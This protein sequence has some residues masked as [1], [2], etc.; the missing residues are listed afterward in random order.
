MRKTGVA[1]DFVILSAVKVITAAS[2]ML[3]TAILSR[4]YSLEQY[5]TYSQAL[6]TMTM[7]SALILFALADASNYFFNR[8]NDEVER[9]RYTNT[10]FLIETAVGF[11]AALLIVG[12]RKSI[13]DYYDNMALLPLT[14]VMALSPLITNYIVLYQVLHVSI[15]NART[16]SVRNLIWAALK[17]GL[18]LTLTT[19]NNS[20]FWM[21]LALLIVDMLSVIYYWVVFAQKRFLVLPYRINIS[22]V[23]HVLR[24]AIPMAAYTICKSLSREISKLFVSRLVGVE[25]LAIF[26]NAAKPLPF[27]LILTAM[28][29]IVMPFITRY[30]NMKDKTNIKKLLRLYFEIGYMTMWIMAGCTLLIPQEIISFLYGDKYLPGRDVFVVYVVY[31]ILQFANISL[32]LSARGKT[33]TLI[34][35]ASI[36]LAS[37]VGLTYVL[38]LWGGILGAAL[39]TLLSSVVTLAL[40]QIFSLQEIGARLCDVFEKTTLLTFMSRAALAAAITA[41]LAWVTAR[42]VEAGVIRLLVVY[43]TFV[44]TTAAFNHKLLISRMKE[45][46]QL[47]YLI[48]DGEF[49]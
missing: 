1:V 18:A 6:I 40:L 49:E 41:A 21:L 34:R 29:T 14:Y 48:N 17:L 26:T 43:P 4:H 19:V 46:N 8:S 20:V 47:R 2:G 11:I 37:T 32:I 15:G 33:R 35:I 25:A 27:D 12:F 13:A 30:A 45:L 38:T 10:I 31:D 3:T 23:K 9:K 22:Y 28:I 5:G 39:A 44:L 36:L 24:F 7:T 16:I 42:H